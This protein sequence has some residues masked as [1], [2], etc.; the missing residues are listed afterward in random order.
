MDAAEEVGSRHALLS[1]GLES[2][3]FYGLAGSACAHCQAP[4]L[5][6]NLT[7]GKGD[8]QGAFTGGGR[9]CFTR[10]GREETGF[11]DFEVEGLAI[12][13]GKS[14]PG[15][16]IGRETSDEVVDGRG[17]ATPVDTA[18]FFED[19]G[20]RGRLYVANEGI[21]RD[22]GKVSG[23]DIV[24]GADREVCAEHHQA[25]MDISYVVCGEDV[26]TLLGDDVAGVDLMF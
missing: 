1:G 8:C 3:D 15:C 16:G 25:V 13:V 11:E 17:G 5:Q 7:G 10:G 18:S 14:G 23:Y 22:W 20:G 4:S 2:E 24:D 9:S 21:L 12:V 26:D 19:F 6:A